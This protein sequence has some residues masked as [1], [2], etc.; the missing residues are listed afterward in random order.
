MSTN[1]VTTTKK[2]Y[3]NTTNT[4]FQQEMKRLQLRLL[5]S[6]DRGSPCNYQQKYHNNENE[7]KC[8]HVAKARPIPHSCQ[9]STTIFQLTLGTKSGLQDLKNYRSH[10]LT[11]TLIS[12]DRLQKSD[13][14]QK[15]DKEN[16]DSLFKTHYQQ[17]SIAVPP[18]VHLQMQKALGHK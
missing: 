18:E 17:S 10:N 6:R 12:K 4:N 13:R 8:Y 1:K 14:L 16:Q 2:I 15:E 3:L 11:G 9:A 5:K 7:E